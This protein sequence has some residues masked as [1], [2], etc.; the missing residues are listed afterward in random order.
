VEFTAATPPRTVCSR[1]CN[2]DADCGEYGLCYAFDFGNRCM[3]YDA[4][5]LGF[6]CPSGWSWSQ[7]FSH[8]PTVGTSWV[9]DGIPAEILSYDD[10]SVDRLTVTFGADYPDLLMIVDSR[11]YAGEP[12]PIGAYNLRAGENGNWATC[13]HCV[14]LGDGCDADGCARVFF[15]AWGKGQF[16]ELSTSS[17][18]LYSGALND[19]VLVEVS[20]DPDDYWST[21][22]PGGACY[23]FQRIGWGSSPLTGGTSAATP[24][25]EPS[26]NQGLSAAGGTAHGTCTTVTFSY[27]AG[28]G[29][30]SVLLS[31]SFNDWATTAG[32]GAEVLTDPDGDGVWT[33]EVALWA[34]AH[35]YKFIVDGQ[36]IADPSHS[37]RTPDGQ[38][39]L[40]SVITVTCP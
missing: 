29:S 28:T 38:G 30:H 24:P 21:P 5:A 2:S 15:Q 39:G 11:L 36:W 12:I 13:T 37:N 6:Y 16:T 14:R 9:A 27:P 18:G 4:A 34:A 26:T 35:E 32:D 8:C 19:L 17:A 23:R 1:E 25:E 40:N 31:G 33:V 10:G 7:D 20:F 3:N 22:V